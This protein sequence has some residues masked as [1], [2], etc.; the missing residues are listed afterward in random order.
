MDPGK[1]LEFGHGNLEFGAHLLGIQ[2]PGKAM[3]F[4]KFSSC[5]RLIGHVAK[6][7]GPKEMAF[8]M[9]NNF[10]F[11]FFPDNTFI[12]LYKLSLYV[13][14]EAGKSLQR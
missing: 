14:P 13:R 5:Q 9:K 2:G 7:S 1:D 8:C 10:K 12:F 4:L 3:D 11:F 6:D